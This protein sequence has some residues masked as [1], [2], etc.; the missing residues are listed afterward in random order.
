MIRKAF[1][2]KLNPGCESEYK[3]R[4][5]EIWSEMVRELSQAGIHDYTIFL[6]RETYTLFAFQELKDNNTAA[7]LPNQEVVKRWW[8]YMKDIM[9]T[10]TDGSPVT[11]NLEEVFHLD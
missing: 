2:M 10:N 11:I 5:D 3:R 9:E 1:K 4:H 8:D 6:D 7:D